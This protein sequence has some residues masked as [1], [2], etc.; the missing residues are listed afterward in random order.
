MVDEKSVS[1]EKFIQEL[2][3][4]EDVIIE[5]TP[6]GPVHMLFYEILK[7]LTNGGKVIIVDELDQLHVFR[8]HL[9]LSGVDTSLI[10][11]S[12][13]IKMGGIIP[14]GNILGKVDL[15]EEPPVRKKHYEEILKPL[16]GKHRFRV[17]VGFDKV[18]LSH[19]NDPKERE[20]I[21]GYLL[22]PHLGDK[23]RI[24]LYIINKD[25]ISDK[26]LKELRE[27]ATR[28]LESRFEGKGFELR[29]VKSIIPE[30]YG[31]RV[32]VLIGE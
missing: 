26:I 4:G 31:Y 7:G 20:R 25:L 19:E 8:T 13:V 22:R 14:T 21:F 32:R 10:D 29:V 11:G 12:P 27:H 5:Y 3:L 30:D 16:T 1:F 28:V 9:H 24:T 2:Q 18:L 17:V 23:S 6:E 15:N